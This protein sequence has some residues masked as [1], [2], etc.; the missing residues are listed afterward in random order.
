M[1]WRRYAELIDPVPSLSNTLKASRISCSES[2]AFIFFAI[3]RRN[4]WKSISPFPKKIGKKCS[5]N[6]IWLSKQSLQNSC[7]FY[8]C[9]NEVN[10][11]I[12]FFL[13]SVHLEVTNILPSEHAMPSIR[14]NGKN[15]FLYIM[16]DE[17]WYS[18]RIVALTILVLS[19]GF[20][21]LSLPSISTSSTRS[22]SSWSEGF[23]PR[24]LMT[25]PNSS[26]DIVPDPSLS[27]NRNASLNSESKK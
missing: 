8:E 19:S 4:S 3:I 20:E 18:N 1:M 5:P 13:C 7:F 11:T 23:C 10:A 27:N 12:C 6:W 22:V 9:S 16:W 14:I 26:L 17:N 25:V 15:V 2:T 21:H 24:D